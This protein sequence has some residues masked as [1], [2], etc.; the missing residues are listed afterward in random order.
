LK[1]QSHIHSR[2]SVRE[3]SLATADQVTSLT[4]AVACLPGP[5]GEVGAIGQGVGVLGAGDPLAEGQ[6]RGEL[7]AGG[8]RIPSHAGPG[9]EVGAIGQ[10]VGVLGA[11]FVLAG[12][13][14]LLS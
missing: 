8:G 9:S 5:V 4:G 14:D 2:A 1:L 12:V 11:E 3:R 6:Q 13:Q 10:G 7:V